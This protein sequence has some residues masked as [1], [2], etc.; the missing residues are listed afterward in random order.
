MPCQVVSAQMSQD[1][2]YQRSSD[3]PDALW[4]YIV[5]TIRETQNFISEYRESGTYENTGIIIDVFSDESPE[6]V[7]LGQEYDDF[8]TTLSIL[9]DIQFP[10]VEPKKYRSLHHIERIIGFYLPFIEGYEEIGKVELYASWKILDAVYTIRDI[11]KALWIKESGNAGRPD[12]PE[13]IKKYLK[14]DNANRSK[15]NVLDEKLHEASR[16]TNKILKKF[17][18]I[19]CVQPAFLNG[20]PVGF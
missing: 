8:Y 13:H 10:Y 1:T 5:K 17:D 7:E 12:V 16:A 3:N 6:L 11:K 20:E 18:G 19:K 2:L 9:A 4:N 15:I 14:Y